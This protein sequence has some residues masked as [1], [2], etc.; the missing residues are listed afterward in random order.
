MGLPE[1]KDLGGVP[2]RPATTTSAANDSDDSST[3]TESHKATEALEKNAKAA[4]AQGEAGN[5]ALQDIDVEAQREDITLEKVGSR[6]SNVSHKTGHSKLSR[7]SKSKTKEKLPPPA[8]P[9]MDL[10]K[11]IVGWE[12]QHDPEMPL[13]FAPSRKWLITGLLSAVTFMTPF[14]SSILAPALSALEKD[15]NE[16]SITKGA[17]PVSIFLLGYAVG[18]LFLSPLSEIYGRNIIL[19]TSSAWF[20][21]WLIGCA[22][23]PSLDTLIFFRFLTGVGGSACQTI[24]GAIIA[25]MFPVSDRGRAMTIWMLGPMFGPS[26]APV[27][28]GFVSETIGWRWV[29]WLAFIPATIAVALMTFLSRETNHQV[30]IAHKTKRLQKELNRPELRSC[31]VDP[32][33]PALSK[34]QILLNGLIRPMKMLFRSAIIFSVS[35]YIAFAYGCLYLLFNTIPIVFQGSYHWSIGITGLVYLTLLIGYGVGLAAFSI[36]SDKTVVRMTAA[37][38][39]VYEPEFR[40]PDCIW[41]ALV[42]PITFFWYGWSADKAVHWIVPVIGIVPFGIGIVG[43]WLPIQAYIVDAYPQ[44]AAS[45]LAA[46]SVL[47]CTVAAFLPLAGPQMYKSLGVGW[48][49]S[50][51]GFIAVAL[52]PIPTLIYKYGKWMRTRFPLTL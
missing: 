40:L 27:I 19:V 15:F 39:G 14:A 1:E 35:L 50:L 41:F 51:L 6:K 28:G 11:G 42:L 8:I 43:V 33:A 3:M 30:L 13:N 45:G 7:L 12:S 38:G 20:C 52:I 2:A 31:Y 49:S 34:G 5:P 25:D 29:N 24:G 21:A 18:P 17:M 36:L 44:Y 26:C 9:V 23:A 16:T 48:G 37:N 22:L 10:D 46:F 4:E 32:D 47:R